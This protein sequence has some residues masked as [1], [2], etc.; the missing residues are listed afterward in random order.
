MT[1]DLNNL[2]KVGDVINFEHKG[3]S[4]PMTVKNARIRY[5]NIDALVTPVN[6]SG[7][8]W[9]QIQSAPR[10]VTKELATA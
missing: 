6:G 2:P 9:L 1:L 10:K 5:G 8:F 7:E 4:F 3:A